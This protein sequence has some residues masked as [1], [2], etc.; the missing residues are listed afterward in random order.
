MRATDF[1]WTKPVPKAW[2]Q[3]LDQL[4]PGE[5][6]SSLH[7]VWQAGFPWRPVQRFE[8]YEVTP[9]ASVARIITQEQIIG[10]DDSLTQALW[11]ALRGPNPRTVGKWVRDPTIPRHMGGQRWKS[12]S[13]VSQAQWYLHQRTGGLPM[14]AWIIEGTNGGHAWQFGQFEKAFLLASGVPAEEVEALVEAWPTP[15]SLP[16]ADYD[17]RV[18][19]ALA[20]RNQLADW[21]ESLR[22]NDRLDRQRAPDLLD[23][24]SLSRAK[25]MKL[26]MLQ[27]IDQQ[28]GDVVSDVPRRLLPN[29]SDLRLISTDEDQDATLETIIEE[30]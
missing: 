11:A 27:W 29:R 18:F 23:R 15:G 2:T 22:W 24:E 14:R 17:Q 10:V 19:R 20:E 6:V 16:Y 1:A 5:N 26:R 12:A 8:I 3:D 25:D 4:N 21:R 30:P 28:V 7:L 9:A 13:L